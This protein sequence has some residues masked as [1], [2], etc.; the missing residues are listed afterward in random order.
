LDFVAIS[1]GKVAAPFARVGWARH[2]IRLEDTADNFAI[3][4]YIVIDV[5]PP[6]GRLSAARPKRDCLWPQPPLIRAAFASRRA[7]RHTAGRV[8]LAC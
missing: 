6:E 5:I 4:Q 1:A 2:S 8:R 7:C 3:R